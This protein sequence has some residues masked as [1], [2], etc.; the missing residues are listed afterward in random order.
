MT[1]KILLTGPEYS[2]KSMVP[3]DVASSMPFL[4]AC[5]SLHAH[6]AA[7]G[8]VEPENRRGEPRAAAVRLLCELLGCAIFP[9]LV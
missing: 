4:V 7:L 6:A 3:I 9:G 2:G 8:V 5:D 1:P